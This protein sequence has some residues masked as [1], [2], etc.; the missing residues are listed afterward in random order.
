MV[1]VAALKG[2]SSSAGQCTVTFGSEL[3]TLVPQSLEYA[4]VSQSDNFE[5]GDGGIEG[6]GAT[7]R[8]KIL[9]C[10]CLAKDD[11]LVNVKAMVE[12]VELVAVATIANAVV[13]SMD[14]TWNYLGGWKV[15]ARKEYAQI[16]FQLCRKADNTLYAAVT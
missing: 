2:V 7:G 8:E 1:G 16:T 14:G 5:N 11:T 4:T 10:T 6:K 15:S 13:S 9:N 3:V 12:P